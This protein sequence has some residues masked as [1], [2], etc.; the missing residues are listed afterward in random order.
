[1]KPQSTKRKNQDNEH[2]FKKKAV[3]GYLVEGNQDVCI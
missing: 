2:G 1:M 3:I